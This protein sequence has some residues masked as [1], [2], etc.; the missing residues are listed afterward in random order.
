MNEIIALLSQ[1]VPSTPTKITL[2]G[3]FLDNFPN[4]VFEK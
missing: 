4:H 2:D 1:E 3:L